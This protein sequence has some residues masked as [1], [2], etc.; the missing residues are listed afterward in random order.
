MTEL[1]GILAFFCPSEPSPDVLGERALG[2]N[3]GHVAFYTLYRPNFVTICSEDGL[4]FV[5]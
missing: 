1:V 5:A 4:A 2:P 3:V